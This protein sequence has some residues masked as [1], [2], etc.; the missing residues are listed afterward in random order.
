MC[1][2]CRR[3]TSLRVETI[4]ERS[5]LPRETWFWAAWEIA[6]AKRGVS[7]M[8]LKQDLGLPSYQTAWRLLHK[9]RRAMV[10]PERTL[11]S[12]MV[13]VDESFVGGGEEGVR[14]RQTH[15]KARVIIAVE[16][17]NGSD[18][19]RVRLQVIPDFAVESMAAFIRTNIAESS[20]IRTDAHPSYEWLSKSD[21]GYFHD[22]VNVAASGKQ[23]HELLKRVHR[24]ASL[25][26]RWLMG[27]HQGSVSNEHLDYYLDEFAFRYNRRSA[28]HPGLRFYRL[29]EQ[30]VATQPTT[31]KQILGGK[32]GVPGLR[33]RRR[34]IP[35]GDPLNR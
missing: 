1:K 30:A 2:A 33:G 23:A 3:R 35:G 20:V 13:E 32:P 17:E 7:A 21:S 27:T 14:G 6:R 25:L 26:K 22:P 34:R 4:F 8:G 29:L 5:H 15:K 18:S 16:L 10:R 12:G 9:F 19:G 28:R 11:L 24:V 31:H